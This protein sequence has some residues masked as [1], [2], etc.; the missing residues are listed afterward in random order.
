M[1]VG[2]KEVACVKDGC[3]VEGYMQFIIKPSRVK[4]LIYV[5]NFVGPTLKLYYDCIQ[6]NLSVEEPNNYHN[7]V[8]M[9]FSSFSGR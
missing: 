4:L 7:I 1:C 6:T 8:F 9:L 5:N 2:S 3:D